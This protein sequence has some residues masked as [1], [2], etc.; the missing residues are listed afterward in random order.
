VLSRAGLSAD[1]KI[2]SFY[3]KAIRVLFLLG[4]G[5]FAIR[6]G[7]ITLKQGLAFL[8]KHLP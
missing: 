3:A 4:I 7:T 8:L 6:E 5:F 1:D 2:W